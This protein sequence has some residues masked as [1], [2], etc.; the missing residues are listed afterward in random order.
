MTRD[1]LA[2][3]P[4]WREV[5]CVETGVTHAADVSAGHP[6]ARFSLCAGEGADRC[7]QPTPLLL[8]LPSVLDS[9]RQSVLAMIRT[10]SET[11]DETNQIAK[12]PSLRWR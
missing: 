11:N 2:F 1:S 7:L 8:T 4:V 9:Q 6:A 5:S 12:N 3:L 10:V